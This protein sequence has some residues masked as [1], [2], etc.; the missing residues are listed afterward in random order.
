[1]PVRSPPNVHD[2]VASYFLGD[3]SPEAEAC[4]WVFESALKLALLVEAEGVEELSPEHYRLVLRR[5]DILLR[6]A[7]RSCPHL[8]ANIWRPIRQEDEE[9]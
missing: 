1:M 5:L 3:Q 8:A 7:S 9:L 4:R 2:L 6:I